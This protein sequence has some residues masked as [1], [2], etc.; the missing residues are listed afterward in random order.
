MTNNTSNLEMAYAN[1]DGFAYANG[2]LVRN[3]N[4]TVYVYYRDK[5]MYASSLL[6]DAKA[7]SKWLGNQGGGVINPETGIVPNDKGSS[8][9]HGPV[10]ADGTVVSLYDVEIGADKVFSIPN[11]MGYKALPVADQEYAIVNLIAPSKDCT[12]SLAPDADDSKYS[13]Y[14]NGHLVQ[15]GTG[16]GAG[17]TDGSTSQR[18]IYNVVYMDENGVMQPFE[19]TI[20]PHSKLGGTIL[21][22]AAKMELTTEVHNGALIVDYVHNKQEIHQ[23]TLMQSNRTTWVA[24]NAGYIT[25]GVGTVL[26]FSDANGNGLWDH[27]TAKRYALKPEDFKPWVFEIRE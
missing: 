9:V 11:D 13:F 24:M 20:I 1:L 16:W 10:A 19:G 8:T 18:I 15:E 2:H 27:L 12:I 23:R 4:Q 7:F 5:E 3:G 25:N 14:R 26:T 21:A 22:P 6:K 17:A